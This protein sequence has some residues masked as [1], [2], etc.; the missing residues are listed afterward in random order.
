M[1]GHRRRLPVGRSPRIAA[2]QG[3]AGQDVTVHRRVDVLRRGVRAEPEW[4]VHGVEPE[5]VAVRFV[6]DGRMRPAP[7]DVAGAVAARY[8]LGRLIAVDAGRRG[9]DGG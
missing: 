7:G 5:D 4:T 6:A 2:D 3:A 8:G 9:W 1:V